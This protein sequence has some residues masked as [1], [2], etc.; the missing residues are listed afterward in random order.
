MTRNENC[1]DLKSASF[2]YFPR[3]DRCFYSLAIHSL[4]ISLYHLFPSSFLDS[5]P[6]FS[7][8]DNDQKVDCK[9][10]YGRLFTAE[11]QKKS[12]SRGKR[13]G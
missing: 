1:V 8:D 4:L 3:P 13:E 7:D 12:L 10:S 11:S 2:L 5:I 6:S 9:K